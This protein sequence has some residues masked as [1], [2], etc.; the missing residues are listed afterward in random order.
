MGA[1]LS[2]AA[3]AI[4]IFVAKALGVQPWVKKKLILESSSK[5]NSK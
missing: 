2:F 1:L 5:T 3:A 4:S